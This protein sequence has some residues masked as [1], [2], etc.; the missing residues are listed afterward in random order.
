MLHISSWKI[1]M[2]HAE[3]SECASYYGIW[4]RCYGWHFSPSVLHWKLKISPS[5]RFAAAPQKNT[6]FS[7]PSTTF[8]GCMQCCLLLK[9]TSNPKHPNMLAEVKLSVTSVNS[10]FKWLIESANKG[11]QS[12]P[13]SN[14]FVGTS[15][16]TVSPYF[17]E[18]PFLKKEG[19]TT[20]ISF[21]SSKTRA[22]HRGFHPPRFFVVHWRNNPC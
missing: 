4:N 10:M 5:K 20:G 8:F 11:S 22:A 14:L 6:S 18:S 1:G 3:N 15:C 13:V 19:S 9:K 16:G 17:F 21:I 7:I 12:F 2:D